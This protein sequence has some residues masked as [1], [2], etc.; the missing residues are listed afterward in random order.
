[1]TV[2]RF[3]SVSSWIGRTLIVTVA[4]APALSRPSSHVTVPSAS[5]HVPVLAEAERKRAPVG[6]VSVSRTREASDDLT[7]VR[8]AG[9]E[10]RREREKAHDGAVAADGR[11]CAAVVRLRAGA[12][13]ADTV[14]DVAD[15]I[16]DEDVAS[17]GRELG[18]V[19]VAGHE[20]RRV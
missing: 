10:V 2:A 14:G 12:V 6:N 1:V 9:D 19:R 17:R 4:L 3:V 8:V 7:R 5:A 18:R 15:A 13:D 20:V 11:V 16:T